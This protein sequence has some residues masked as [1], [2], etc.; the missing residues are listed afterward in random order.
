M[1]IKYFKNKNYDEFTTMQ[2]L[3]HNKSSKIFKL[4]YFTFKCIVAL[5]QYP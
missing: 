5:N 2:S 1:Y 3:Y 4:I